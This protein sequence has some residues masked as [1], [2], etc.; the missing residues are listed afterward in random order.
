MVGRGNGGGARGPRGPAHVNSTAVLLAWRSLW[1]HRRRTLITLTSIGVGLAAVVFFLSLA[2]GMYSQLIRDAVRLGAGHLTFEDAAYRDAPA[3]DLRV[4]GTG[5]LRARLEAMPEVEG[6]KTLILGQ[7]VARSGVDAVGVSL[8]GIEPSVEARTSPLAKKIVEGRFLEDGDGPKVLVGRQLADRLRLAEGRKLVLSTNDASGALVEA[9]FR[10][11]GIFETGAEELDG[12]LVQAPIDEVR[13]VYGLASGEATQLGLVLRDPD[14]QEEVRARVT[15]L[16]S[17]VGVVV[18]GWQEVLPELAAFIRLD[19]VSDGTFE[20]LLLVLVLF[21]IFNTIL[22]S[23][24]EREREFAV[25]LAIGTPPSL[26]AR[27]LLF[28]ALF[29]GL[30]GSALGLAVGGAVGQ[31]V[32]VYGW[33]L[34]SLYEEGLS[35]SGLA[36]STTL[37]AEVKPGLLVFLGSVVCGATVLLGLLPMRRALRIPIADTLR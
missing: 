17:E 4:R 10:V 1:R 37:H 7:G 15:P 22:M 26:L 21:T 28:E 20:G 30:L 12:Y 27:Q 35:I 6:T 29:L 13:R 14:S 24:L 18:R 31:V 8:M 11:Q 3:V 34:S 36:V 16:A 33:D 5:E 9:L 23:V 19:R 32:H 25:M 2:E